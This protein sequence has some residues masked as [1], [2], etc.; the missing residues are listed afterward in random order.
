M[1]LGREMGDIDPVMSEMGKRE[2]RRMGTMVV[3]EW[4]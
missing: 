3:G 1:G 2:E 4:M